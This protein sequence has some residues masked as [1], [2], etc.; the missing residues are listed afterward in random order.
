MAVYFKCP[1]CGEYIMEWQG[2]LTIDF[3]KLLFKCP[4]CGGTMTL[5][6][7]IDVTPHS[8]VYQQLFKDLGERDLNSI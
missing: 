5:D 7:T 8:G 6:D 2:E 3:E 1:H 4:E